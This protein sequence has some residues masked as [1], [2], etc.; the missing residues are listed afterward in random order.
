MKGK[1]KFYLPV[2]DCFLPANDIGWAFCLL[3][4]KKIAESL[5]FLISLR[6]KKM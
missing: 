5:S 2:G 4:I 6:Q 1:M 3:L